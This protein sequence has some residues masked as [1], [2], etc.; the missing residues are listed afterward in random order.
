MN[1][2]SNDAKVDLT[3]ITGRKFGRTPDILECLANLSSDEVFTHPKVVNEMLDLLPKEVWEN[4]E[5]K[6]LDP[7]CKSGV[8]LREIAKRLLVGLEFAIPDE[9]ERRGH[10]FKE[11]L[12]G[13]GLTAITSEV[14]R[15]SLYCSKD[16]N[17][18]GSAVAMPTQ[19]GSIF[20]EE[21]KHTFEG[22]KG[23]LS[24]KYCGAPDPDNS[25]LQS[26]AINSETHAYSFIHPNKLSIKTMKFDV[27]I[28]NPPYQLKDG[29]SGA[30]SKPLYHLF[31]Q[32][33]KLLKPTYLAMIV[34]SRWFA[35]GKG[36]D[37]FREEMLQDATISHL[38]DFPNASDC[39]P[40]VKIEGGVCYFLKNSHYAGSCAITTV[41]NNT[42]DTLKRPLNE[43]GTFIRFNSAMAI[44]KKVCL[45]KLPSMQLQVSSRKPFGLTTT[46]MPLK[47]G[48]IKLY[49]NKAIGY[50]N[51]GLLD[52]GLGLV[53][54][55]KVLTTYAYGLNGGY[56]HQVM[57][58]PLIAAPGSACTETYLVV[59][60]YDS[61]LEAKNLAD[62]FKTRFFRF[63]VLL[64]KNTQH[65][66]KD[67]YEFVPQLDMTK[68]WD[69]EAL[70]NH[71]GITPK[72]REFI[73]S[74]IKE[75]E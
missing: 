21:I 12:Y 54:K 55:W 6:W 50:Y 69:D 40:D 56:P 58:K 31:I 57:G 51:K 41:L 66:T 13:L 20:F 39:F 62:Y 34:P 15:R 70:Y 38:V 68:A 8:F 32:A 11:M 19:Q 7:C 28:G 53:T 17:G 14:A 45:F 63:L 64:K 26:E 33:A 24:C 71:F 52:G 44:L 65:G 4:P 46:V 10:I 9:A 3:Y 30:S 18:E 29:G 23:K 74:L 1:T 49:A 37:K 43:Y 27:I 47:S 36:L 22:S 73:E 59:G 35:G 72:E 61:E 48:D 42:R 25:D 16:A 5:L 60:S 67:K 2:E 75:M